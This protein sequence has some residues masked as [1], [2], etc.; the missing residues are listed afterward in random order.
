MSGGLRAGG[1]RDGSRAVRPARNA[2][3]GQRVARLVDGD[4][5]AGEHQVSFAP[6][7]L[8]AGMYFIVL[9]AGSTR[10]SRG[11]VLIP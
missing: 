7:G 8:A 4:E 6:R 9:N 3:A 11:A 2:T 10:I 1:R 5:D